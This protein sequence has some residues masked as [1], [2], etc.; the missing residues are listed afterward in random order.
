MN[1]LFRKSPYLFWQSPVVNKK[2]KELD[3]HTKE[4]GLKAIF[5]CKNVPYSSTVPNKLRW[6]IKSISKENK[7][8]MQCFGSGSPWI[9]IKM[10]TLDPDPDPH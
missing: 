6:F 1:L 9:R 3:S 5:P 10:A 8:C 7:C 2:E 4:I